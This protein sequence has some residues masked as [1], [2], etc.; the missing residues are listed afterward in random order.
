MYVTGRYNVQ[1]PWKSNK[2]DLPTNF[3]LSKKRLNSLQNSLNKKDPEVIKKYNNQLLE[4]P[5]LGFIEKAICS[6]EWMG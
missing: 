1:L 3:V 6:K 4:H 5:N 2:H